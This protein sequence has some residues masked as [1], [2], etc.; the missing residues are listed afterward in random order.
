MNK[1][2]E[3]HVSTLNVMKMRNCRIFYPFTLSEKI[4]HTNLQKY[5]CKFEKKKPLYFSNF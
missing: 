3:K 1:P 4:S 5:L 2:Y